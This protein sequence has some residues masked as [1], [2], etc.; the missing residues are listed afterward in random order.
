MLFYLTDSLI[1]DRTSPQFTG[2]RKAAWYIAISVL[3]SKHLLRGDYD[4]LKFLEKVFE[5]D[6][7]IYPLFHQLVARY[8]TYTVP[9][10]I[11]RYIEV[12]NG[13]CN[14]FKG[15]GHQIKQLPYT[16][17]DDS[18][19]VQAMT[20]VTE[21]EDDCALF[22]Y[23]IR[24]Y[25]KVNHLNY[26]CCFS[27]QG[28]GGSRTDTAVKTCLKDG[29]MVTCITDSDQRYEG[30]PLDSK[31]CGVKCSKIKAFDKIYYFLRLPVLEVENLIPL[32][33]FNM[34]DWSRDENRKDKEAFDK[35]CN[36]AHSEL[37]LPYFDIKEGIKKEYILQYGTG[38]EKYAAMC[39]YC[40]PSIMKGKQFHQYVNDLDNDELVYRR[41]RKRP[42]G[43]LAPLY[44]KDEVPEPELMNFQL[45]AWTEIASLLLDAT[46]A[47]YKEA[48]T[49]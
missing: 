2:I 21:D 5:N 35:L 23:M 32:N 6:E 14:E 38:M 11:C 10:D 28:G 22:G 30:Q 17:F 47:R 40:N 42:M 49:V 26:H 1:V 13:E 33:H 45:E 31:S 43:E 4:V 46:C 37:I 39:C 24:H 48:I 44:R 12:V 16:F 8:S 15:G 34:L 20:V 18:K 3:E 25:Q 7:E 19:K 27:Q 29:K 36:N 9:D 41:L